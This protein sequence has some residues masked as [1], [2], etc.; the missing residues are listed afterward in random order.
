[1]IYKTIFT[2]LTEKLKTENVKPFSVSGSNPRS[3]SYDS[4]TNLLI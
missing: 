2:Y 3:R 1:M 4:C